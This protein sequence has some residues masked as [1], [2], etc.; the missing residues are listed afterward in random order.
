M[1]RAMTALAAAL[2]LAASA[3]TS[4]GAS[5]GGGSQFC[6]YLYNPVAGNYIVFTQTY[7][8]YKNGSEGK[9]Y[10]TNRPPASCNFEGEIIP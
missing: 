5:N 8:Q 2:A 9:S 6:Y 3:A 1:K 10:T 4:A 7:G